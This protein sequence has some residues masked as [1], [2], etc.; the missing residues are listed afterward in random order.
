L[1]I[2]VDQPPTHRPPGYGTNTMQVPEIPNEN[3]D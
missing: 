1:I 3:N 2:T